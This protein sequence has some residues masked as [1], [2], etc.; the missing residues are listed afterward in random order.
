MEKW[1]GI[2][3]IDDSTKPDDLYPPGKGTGLVE[4]DF[5]KDPPSMFADPSAMP[6]IDESHW[7]GLIKEQDEQQSSLMHHRMTGN[8]GQMIPSLDQGSNGYCW[9]HSTVNTIHLRRAYMH[10]PFVAL[11]AYSVCATIM[12]GRNEGGWC[13]LSAK[14]LR[15][16]GVCSQKLWPQGDR[17]Y[18]KYQTPEVLADMA[19]HKITADYVDLA[20]PVYNQNLTWKQVASCLFSGIPCAVDFNWWAHSVCALRIIEV[21]GGSFGLLIWNSWGD[22]WG[23][24]GMGIL[25]GNKMYPDGAV[26]TVGTTVS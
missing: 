2:P 7:K 23:D 26:A 12:K 6:V 8:N 1:N 18:Q 9:G 5:S 11:S 15:E 14:F 4:R 10:Q 16:T 17:N 20:K 13:G 21:E 22:G 25:R 19:K 3:I 24:K